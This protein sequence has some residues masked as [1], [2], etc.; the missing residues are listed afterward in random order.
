MRYVKAVEDT[1][2]MAVEAINEEKLVLKFTSQIEV[3]LQPADAQNV[4]DELGIYERK[5]L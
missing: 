3:T 2:R 4:P 1:K 5:L